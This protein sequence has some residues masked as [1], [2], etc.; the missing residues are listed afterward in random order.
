MAITYLFFVSI[1]WATVNH[2]VCI[3]YIL[4]RKGVILVEKSFTH[5]GAGLAELVDWLLGVFKSTPETIALTI[6]KWLSFPGHT[7]SNTRLGRL[8]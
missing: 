6:L 4:Y 3:L 8:C 1:D 2:Q 7:I 5:N